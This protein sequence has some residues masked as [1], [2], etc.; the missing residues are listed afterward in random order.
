[1]ITDNFRYYIDTS[2]KCIFT[3][4]SN[5]LTFHSFADRTGKAETHPDFDPDFHSIVDIS[6]C[7]VRLSSD[8]IR[9]M[10][11]IAGK[12]YENQTLGKDAFIVNSVIGHGLTRMFTSSIPNYQ[13]RSQIFDI[14]T[15]SV[16]QDLKAWLDLPDDYVFPTFMKMRCDGI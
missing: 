5:V 7:D 3:K 15:G 4:Y 13:A 10:A 6:D 16:A 11:K 1:M 14:S 2:A 8:E 12:I 9:E